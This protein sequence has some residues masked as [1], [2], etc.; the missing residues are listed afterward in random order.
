MIRSILIKQCIEHGGECYR[1]CDVGPEFDPPYEGACECELVPIPPDSSAHIVGPGHRGWLNFPRPEEPYE[2]ELNCA[3]NCGVAQVICWIDGGAYTGEIA[4]GANVGDICLPGEPG[5]SEAVRIEIERDHIG[6]TPNILLWD[7]EECTEDQI[8]GTCPG[9]P[10]HI[11]GTGCTLIL[12]V[13]EIDLYRKP[14][15][16]PPDLCAPNV[17][18]IKAQRLCDCTSDCG[19]TIGGEPL[20]GQVRA[21]SLIE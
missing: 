3:G 17:K 11:V 20:P 6:E 19:S 1:V 16:R 13:L 7:D 10:Y 9:T 21:V 18:I 4:I 2:D 8:L 15:F 5:V 12:D 14:E